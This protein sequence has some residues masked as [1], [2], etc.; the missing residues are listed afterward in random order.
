MDLSTRNESAKG[1]ISA[2]KLPAAGVLLI[3]CITGW[4]FM[5]LELLGVRVLT[6]YFG[7]AIYV[8]TGSVIGI[9]LLSLSVGYMLGGWLSNRPSSRTT[10]GLCVVAAGLWLCALPYFIEPVCERIFD[11]GLDEKWGSLR[12]LHCLHCR[13]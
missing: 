10:V 3:V 13:R 11:T 4:I 1:A 6:P 2:G 7:S 12:R 5:Q 8:V 9:F